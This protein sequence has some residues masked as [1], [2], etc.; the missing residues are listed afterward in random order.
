MID[1]PK[2]F[3]TLTGN[4]PFAWQKRLYERFLAGEIPSSC[5][6]PTGLG[7]T[8]VIAIWLLA[9]AEKLI[10]NPQANKISRRL[11]YVVDRRVIVDQATDEAQKILCRL[12]EFENSD[13]DDLKA[14][15]FALQNSSFL[16]ERKKDDKESDVIALSTLRGEYADNRE[17]CLDPSRPAI[18]VGTIDMIG[19][20]LLFSAYGG[21]GESY[22]ALQ[23]GLLGQDSLIVIDEAHL[24]PA[25]IEM[26]RPLKKLVNRKETIKPFEI[27][28]L[29]A[30]PLAE[31]DEE[32]RLTL[33]KDAPE[34]LINKIAAL[35]L[36]AEKIIKWHS[37]SV[38]EDTLKSKKY[39]ELLRTELAKEMAKVAAQYKDLSVSV[40]VFGREVELV[41][42]IQAELIDTHKIEK[43][44]VR[45]MTGGMRGFER[46]NLVKDK[47]F[48]R[49]DPNRDR[50][51]KGDAFFLIATS[52]AEVGINLDA[53]FAV[54]DAT[55]ADSFIQRLGRVNRFGYG[56]AVV[57]IVHPENPEILEKVSEEVRATFQELKRHESLDASPLAL[58]G[59]KFPLN[60][61]PPKPISPPL[62]SARI[63]DWAMTSLKQDDFRRPLVSYWLRGVT[64]NISPETSLCWRADLIFANTDRRKIATVKT[65][66][67]KSRECAREATGR[68]AAMIRAIAEN[69][70]LLEHKVVFISAGNKYEVLSI[71][72]LN[73]LEE[74]ELFS[75]LIFATVVFPCE[76]G[77]LDD[78]GMTVSDG[79]NVKPVFDVVEKSQEANE[80]IEWLR[81]ILTEID[82]GKIKAEKMSDEP[83]SFDNY[84]ESF[85][86]AIKKIAD[87]DKRSI[88]EIRFR[89][90]EETEDDE[91]AR[92]N[93]RRLVYFINKKSPE[94]YL[95]D[96][97]VIGEEL[98]ADEESETASI[99]FAKDAKDKI[100]GEIAVEEHNK[101]VANFAGKLAR[102]LH[103][104]DELIEV[105]ELAGANHDKGKARQCWQNAV[106][107][108]D[109]PG[110]I[111]AK[112]NQ[113]WF[114][115]KY[116]NYYRHEFGSLIE[117]EESDEL[118][119]HPHRDLIL[120][121][122]AAHHGYARP[123][124]PER[125]FDRE[126]PNG[127]NHEVAERT[128]L[129][130]ANLQIKYGWWQ[131][132][133]L[134]AILKA[135]DALA[136]RAE[137]EGEI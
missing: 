111:L 95:T 119:S 37:F 49:F 13:N 70:K 114:D 41:K 73:S 125:A 62:D 115:H 107:N 23:A 76:A 81:V 67:V 116:N 34:D 35:R 85:P 123:H 38:S 80:K 61:Y 93:E 30:T 46:D 78:Y 75:K 121:L 6:I 102:K 71:A 130:F 4:P 112:S 19:S 103:L 97:S 51:E 63:D 52:V 87:K 65:V 15:F 47:V 56:E 132:A 86:E 100:K 53:D 90:S 1:F 29:S 21:V 31:I 27:M 106:G 128:M 48:E 16:A 64:E 45:R 50:T 104:N 127:A 54:C 39:A 105:L 68:A 43:D 12:S 134:E 135:A 99:G 101:D 117:A 14:I 120:H 20:R 94:G 77:G 137:A 11:V 69:D 122:I 89:V 8:S 22:K 24:S 17:W 84:Y 58:R 40:I 72:D 10:E 42:K 133:Y 82:D 98:G 25:F 36:N 28:S 57:K 74:K 7:K 79:K 131:L 124:F 129:R 108:F 110:K 3:E 59:I 60:C 96:D 5:D 109:F 32:K 83:Y 92:S 55:S 33:E 9:L 26:L 126:N 18:I 91:D 66:H 118:E 44:Q 136:S 113:N 88:K 2:C